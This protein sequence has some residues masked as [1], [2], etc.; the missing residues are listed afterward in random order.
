MEEFRKFFKGV[1][2][3]RKDNAGKRSM[4]MTPTIISFATLTGSSLA[5]F[6]LDILRIFMLLH[7]HAR[8]IQGCLESF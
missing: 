4:I 6:T 2:D 5:R 3:P 1:K 8:G 7:A